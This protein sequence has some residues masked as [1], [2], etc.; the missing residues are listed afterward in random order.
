MRWR[1]IA[2]GIVGV[3]IV[4]GVVWLTG[5]GGGKLDRGGAENALRNYHDQRVATPATDVRCQRAGS[6]WR[7]EFREEGRP[8]HGSVAGDAGNP[9]VVYFCSARTARV[10]K[11]P[12]PTLRTFT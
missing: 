10:T 2:S 5:G 9:A 1:W 4:L 11:Q 6:V 7:C 12:A 3:A 8:C